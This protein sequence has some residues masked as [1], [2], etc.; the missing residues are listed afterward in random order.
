MTQPTS[1]VTKVREGHLLV[2]NTFK[3]AN[4]ITLSE[5]A[6]KTL[7]AIRDEVGECFNDDVAREWTLEMTGKGEVR[8]SVNV[9]NDRTYVHVRAW[10]GLFPTR[11]GTCIRDWEAF[12]KMLCER[13]DDVDSG[14]GVDEDDEETRLGLETY[15][16]ILTEAAGTEV[17]RLCYGCV[18]DSPSQLDHPCVMGCDQMAAEAVGNVSVTPEYFAV[19]LAQAAMERSY[20]LTK[21]PRQLMEDIIIPKHDAI[22][23]DSLRVTY[24][25]QASVRMSR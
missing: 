12:A 5:R 19:R 13:N 10:N 1:T 7:I 16:N 24:G 8:A 3:P 14:I 18:S 17:R 15:R 23:R 11:V 6:W 20:V 2:G 21:F 9:F 22:I 4:A 25:T